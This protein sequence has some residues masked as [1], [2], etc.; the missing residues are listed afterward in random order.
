MKQSIEIDKAAFSKDKHVI[1]SVIY[2]P[3][4]TD[5]EI[6][7]EHISILLNKLTKLISIFLSNGWL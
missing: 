1:I 6:F 7:N 4:G 5:L 3:P 2:I